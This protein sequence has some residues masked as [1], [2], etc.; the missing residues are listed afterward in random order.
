MGFN[1]IGGDPEI[2]DAEPDSKIEDAEQKQSESNSGYAGV[3][4]E[5]RDKELLAQ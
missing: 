4:I 2:D 1:L 5:E 3:N